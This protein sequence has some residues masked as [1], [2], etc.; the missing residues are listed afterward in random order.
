MER[1][2][3]Y[4]LYALLEAILDNCFKTLDKLD[5][6]VEKL[7]FNQTK[8]D[9]SSDVLV[10]IESHKK[11]VHLIKKSILP[12]KE[13]TQLVERGDEDPDDCCGHFYSLT[14]FSALVV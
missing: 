3:D 5:D 7:K 4:L 2:A 13:F 9:F 1:T 8:G 6:K 12:I 14:L 11:S 10:S